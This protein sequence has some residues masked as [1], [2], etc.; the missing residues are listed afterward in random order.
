MAALFLRESDVAEL[1]TMDMAIDAITNVFRRHSMTE[2]ANISRGRARTDKGMLH[3]MGAAAKTL[4]VMGCKLYS[5]TRERSQFLVLLYDGSTGEL[6]A[7][8]EADR[9][10]ATRTGAA[11]GVATAFMARTDAKTVGVFG[12][13]KQARTQLLG[14]S[15]VRSLEMA[16]VYSPTAARR[17]LFAA[18][19]SETIGVPVTAAI[20]PE[21]AAENMDIV[22]TATSSVEP[23]LSAEWIAA[24]THLNVVGSNF[25]G[26]TEIDVETVRKC[27]PIVVDDKDQARLEAGD[28]VRAVDA[29]VIRWSDV[30]Q[31]GDVV[32]GRRPAR[33]EPTDITLFKSV[34]VAFE[35]VAVAKVVYDRA[36]EIGIGQALPF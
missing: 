34:G 25:V 9:M 2:V 18:E 8:M 4:G 33:H 27:D 7:V 11:S 31:L 12:S 6:L 14:V 22:V 29:G 30:V 17:E 36:R 24:G 10:G 16:C 1:L 35:D 15:R 26:K 3:I 21:S 23:V 19:M 13:G 32:T 28:V 20:R 5:T